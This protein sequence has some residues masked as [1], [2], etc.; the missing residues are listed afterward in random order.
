MFVSKRLKSLSCFNA[1]NIFGKKYIS[2]TI[3]Y[4][5]LNTNT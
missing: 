3:N 1:N 4:L 5:I 2:S